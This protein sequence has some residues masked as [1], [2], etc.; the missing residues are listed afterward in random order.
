MEKKTEVKNRPAEFSRVAKVIA[1]AGSVLCSLLIWLYAIGYDNTLF[2]E[3]FKGITVEIRGDAELAER[4]GYTLAAQQKFSSITITAQGKRSELNALSP[5]DF[6]AVVDVSQVDKAGFNEMK[7][8]VD[9]PNGIEV[10]WQS[11]TTARVFVDEFTQI[12]DL[13]AVTVDTG[14]DYVM[15]EGVTFVSAVSNPMYV[16][17]SGP[18]TVLAEIAGAYVNFP[19]NGHEI[20]NTVSGEGKIELRNKNGEVINNPYVTVSEKSAYVVV[21]VKKQKTVGFVIS[22]SGGLFSAEELNYPVP[23]PQQI[24]VSGSPDVINA[25][26]DNIVLTI[27]ESKIEKVQTFEFFINDYLPN[28]VTVDDPVSKVSVTVKVPDLIVRKYNI[29]ANKITVNNLPENYEFSVK[30][31]IEVTVRAI[32]DASDNKKD[33][34]KGFGAENISA[35]LDFDNAKVNDD[36]S[37]TVNADI[38]VNGEF[39]NLIVLSKDY[40]V[41]FTANQI[42][43]PNFGEAEISDIELN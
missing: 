41:T 5:E 19:L 38:S 13:L 36:G 11:S 20:S 28:G 32:K 3:D 43:D 2:T 15:T 30:N 6:T 22:Y 25:M 12:N 39:G 16:N 29:P 8:Y 23:A 4:K 34:F 42:I 35:V 26:P 17:V 18:K 40:P 10:I 27:D 37:Y 21:N 24:K 31:G 9:S 1:I 33:P 7:I 14:N